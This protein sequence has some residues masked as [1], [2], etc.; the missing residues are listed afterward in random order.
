MTSSTDDNICNIFAKSIKELQVNN[1]KK[2][3]W[4]GLMFHGKQ[5]F[6]WFACQLVWCICP[7]CQSTHSEKQVQKCKWVSLDWSRIV[8]VKN[9]VRTASKKWKCQWPKQVQTKKMPGL[10][11]STYED[12]EK[13]FS[14]KLKESLLNIIFDRTKSCT[15][16]SERQPM[17]C[18][19]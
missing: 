1:F 13:H 17:F 15:Y 2:A 12:Q 18:V 8:K 14:T 19:E 7:G 6:K 9:K 16:P 4:S 10:N 3:D 5:L 11:V